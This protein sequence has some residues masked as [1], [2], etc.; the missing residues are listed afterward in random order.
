VIP[1]TD[2]LDSK[3][4]STC[5]PVLKLLD[6]AFS[7]TYAGGSMF[8]VLA[9]AELGPPQVDDEA[10]ASTEEPSASDRTTACT[11]DRIATATSSEVGGGVVVVVVIAD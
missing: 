10:A 2:I 9:H 8:V 6:T 1:L 3:V 5:W 11:S 7:A 4:D